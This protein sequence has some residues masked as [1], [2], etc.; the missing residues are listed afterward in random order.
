VTEVGYVDLAEGD[1]QAT[2][3]VWQSKATGTSEG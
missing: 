3:D 1:L 2:R